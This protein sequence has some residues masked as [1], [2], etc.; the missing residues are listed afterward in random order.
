MCGCKNKHKALLGMRKWTELI[1]FLPS[2]V[3][4]KY[5]E[6]AIQQYALNHEDHEER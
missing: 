3:Q 2:G 5:T 4:T 1:R 6:L